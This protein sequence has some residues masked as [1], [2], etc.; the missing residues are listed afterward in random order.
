MPASGPK[1][2]ENLRSGQAKHDSTAKVVPK[3]NT[4]TYNN[5]ANDDDE[6]NADQIE[7]EIE[8]VR[9]DIEEAERQELEKNKSALAA[10]IEVTGF[11]VRS[12]FDK[13]LGNADIS[14]AEIDQMVE[15]VESKLE[16]ATIGELEKEAD[17]IAQ[18]L[19]DNIE[20]E[21]FNGND[22]GLTVEEIRSDII[23]NEE[24][25]IR[26]MNQQIEEK[27]ERMKQMMQQ[28]AQE[29]EIEILEK[30]LEEKLNKK[31]KVIIVDEELSF[32][33]K[34]LD[35]LF[36]GANDQDVSSGGSAPVVGGSDDMRSGS[37][38]ASNDETQSNSADDADSNSNDDDDTGTTDDDV[39]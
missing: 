22:Q 27:A 36:T 33:D 28:K 4:N 30:R 15:E 16:E 2:D 37:N 29:F 24:V 32:A 38:D 34:I 14:A 19:E 23:D 18:T 20:G 5:A 8:I 26:E 35:G 39:A 17:E 7:E 12:A 21:A 25:A 13:L 6:A 9:G 10:A 31:V 11:Y 1:P 3:T